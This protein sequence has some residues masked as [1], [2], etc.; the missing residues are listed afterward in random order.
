LL[1]WLHFVVSALKGVFFSLFTLPLAVSMHTNNTQ[2]QA[3]RTRITKRHNL[4]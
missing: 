3:E 4:Q 1:C 2:Q